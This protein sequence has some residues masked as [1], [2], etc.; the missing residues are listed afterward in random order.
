MSEVTF[1]SF[2]AENYIENGLSLGIFCSRTDRDEPKHTHGFVEIIYVLDG[3]CDHLVNGTRHTLSRGDMLFINYNST[4][5][6]FTGGKPFT[7]YNICFS[8]EVIAE[9]IINRENAFDLLSL[10][11]IDEIKSADNLVCK[12][13]FDA[14]ER[15]RVESMLSDM[16][17]EYLADMPERRAVLESY[18][19]IL[20]A[21]ILRRFEPTVSKRECGGGISR[22][23]LDFIDSNLGERL[24][25]S[26]LAKKCFYNPSY[27]SRSFKERFGVTL[28]EYISRAR[29]EAAARML[30]ESDMPTSEIAIECGFSDKSALYRAFSK[31]Y[32]MTPK[33]YR[34]SSGAAKK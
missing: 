4:H 27:F 18:M 10:T 17:A 32:G 22:D 23:I 34:S 15:M 33:E 14:D 8:P 21:K 25:L 26:A 9:R 2:K 29:A 11:A 1:K 3:H 19:T 28:V 5:E 16:Y 31:Y 30:L 20:V 13:T 12:I 7:Y 24:T 6:F